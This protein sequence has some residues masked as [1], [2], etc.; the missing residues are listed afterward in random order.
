VSCKQLSRHNSTVA[1]SSPTVT[2]RSA[3]AS[4]F[5]QQSSPG[6]NLG[7]I[8]FRES[9]LNCYKCSVFTGVSCMV[10]QSVLAYVRSDSESV[11]C[12]CGCGPNT[13]TVVQKVM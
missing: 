6:L 3:D 11:S 2:S 5:H 1:Q 10:C 4:Q 7:Q 9:K 13:C 12:V 8:L